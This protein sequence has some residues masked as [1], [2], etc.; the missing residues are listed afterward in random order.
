VPIQDPRALLSRL[1][2]EQSECSW[3]E[4][5][6]NNCD[7]LLIGQT[8]SACANAAMLAERE[9]GFIVWGIENKSKLRIGTAVRLSE[10]KKGGENLS[11]W[12]NRLVEPHLMMEFFDFEDGGLAFCVIAVEPSYDRPVR[13][14]GEEF[15][16][17]GENVKRLKD[18]PDHE[19][20]LWLA[21]GRHKFETGIAMAHQSQQSLLQMLDAGAYYRLKGENVP[22]RESEIIR[23]LI[24]RGYVKEDMEGGYDITNLG[25]LLFASDIQQFPSISGKSTRVVHYVGKDKAKSQGET[26]GRRGYGVGFEGLLA[27][28][29]ARLPREERIQ[30]GVRRSVSAYS[31]IAIREILANALIHQDFTLGGT[32]PVVEIYEDRVEVTNPGNSLI[33]LDRIIDERRSRNEKL[34]SAM[35]DIGICE[36]RGSGIDKAIIDVEERA[37]PAPE[38]FASQ[39]SMRVVIFSRKTFRQLSRE[40]RV[41][42]CFCH[43]VVRWLRHDPM[44]NSS[45]RTRFTLP[46][47]E[48][49][50]ASAVIADARRAGR[51]VYADPTQGRR[52]ARYVPYWAG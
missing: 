42:A 7:P 36:E 33:E 10:V 41:W 16:R 20:S 44:T 49:Q 1:L 11:N 29:V 13:F 21:T 26:E 23:A 35:R 32:G 37:L 45:L 38:F 15:I 28:I 47:D 6:H 43:S 9:R 40:D 31:E 39:D 17:I 30:G 5:K 46:D 27:F 34:A 24:A 22:A 50:A 2:K 25:A 19:R 3:L 52:N 51:I 48:Y 18:F 4:F 8:I 14:S 12:L